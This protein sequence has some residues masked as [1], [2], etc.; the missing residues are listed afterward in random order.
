MSAITKEIEGSSLIRG[1]YEMVTKE[2]F[3]RAAS[4]PLTGV[5]KLPDM[6]A[7]APNEGVVH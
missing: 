7:P 3:G 5:E 1:S 6:P 4:V 2:L